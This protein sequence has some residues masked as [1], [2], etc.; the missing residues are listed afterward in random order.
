MIL[1]SVV[2]AFHETKSWKN[3]RR[4]RIPPVYRPEVTRTL[5]RTR[6]L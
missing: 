4:F 1:R 5:A 6:V 3:A 2:L